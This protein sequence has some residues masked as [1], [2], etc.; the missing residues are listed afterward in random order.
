M[1][2]DT[3]HTQDEA[4]VSRRKRFAL[5][6]VWLIPLGAALIGCWLLYQNIV[7][8]GPEITLHLNSAEGLEAG[9]T[10][11]KV[12]NVEVGHIDSVRL[13]DDYANVIVTAQMKPDTKALLAS[14]SVFWVVKPRV[15]FQGVSGLS[16]LLSGAYIQMQ[17]GKSSQSSHSFMVLDHPPLTPAG[18]PGVSVILTSDGGATLSPGDPVIYQGQPVGRVETAKF[19]VAENRMSYT[20]FIRAPFDTKVSRGT[21][22]WSRSGIQFHVGAEGI[23]VETGSLQAIFSGGV[24]FGLLKGVDAGSKADNGATF[25][26]Y[27]THRAAEQDRFNEK[28]RYILLASNS[29]RGLYAGAPVEYRGVRIGTVLQVPFF[30]K[31]VTFHKFADSRMPLL[32]AIEP[33][34]ISSRWIDWTLPEWRQHIRIFE[35]KGMRATIT[36]ANLLTGAKFIEL[37]FYPGVPAYT[38]KMIGEYPVFPIQPN[39]L[40][41]IPQQV[42]SLLK[43]INDLKLS[44]LVAQMQNTLTT[45]NA[46]LGEVRTAVDNLNKILATGSARELPDELQSSLREMRHTLKAYQ[47]GAPVYRNLNL[48]LER[49]NRVLGN[50]APAA[51]TLR[52]KPNALIFGSSEDPDPIPRA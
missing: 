5:S 49:L 13:S 37:Q 38:E 27:A 21:Q 7:S 48:S 30:P 45:S 29:V 52:D 22:F 8:R 14:D 36:D 31:G 24:T 4:T 47:Q 46:T 2:D 34:R 43:K 50:L 41:N 3:D 26:L 16:T 15:S 44:Q 39:S 11:I 42:S 33:Q 12:R 25:K 28:I 32:I 10:P 6:P 20:L 51:R 19:S 40:S 17:P 23:D 9:K 1:T 18:T 35:K